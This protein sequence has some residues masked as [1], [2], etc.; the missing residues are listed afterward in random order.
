MLKLM[1]LTSLPIYIYNFPKAIGFDLIPGILER[2][3]KDSGSVPELNGNGD[4]EFDV[5]PISGLPSYIASLQA[6]SLMAMV[7]I[8]EAIGDEAMVKRASEALAKGTLNNLFDGSKF[9]NEAVV[10][11]KGIL[12]ELS[13]MRLSI[14]QCMRFT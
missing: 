4:T 5:T 6:A 2:L 12:L 11:L 10:K 3:L 1:E 13:Q 8:A 9:I 7:K 14:H